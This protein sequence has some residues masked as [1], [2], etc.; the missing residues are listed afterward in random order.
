MKAKL[1]FLA[2]ALVAVTPWGRTAR[3][4]VDRADPA[5][6]PGNGGAVY[7]MTNNAADNRVLVYRRDPNGLLTFDR[8][9]PTYGRGSGG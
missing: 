6:G 1:T 2:C 7:A 3:A 8:A 9:V 4:Q 5:A